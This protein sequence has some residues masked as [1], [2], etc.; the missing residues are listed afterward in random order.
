M[1]ESGLVLISSILGTL[2]GIT[3]IGILHYYGVI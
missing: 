2:F 1:S 3:V